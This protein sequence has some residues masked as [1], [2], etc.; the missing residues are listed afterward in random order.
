[1]ERGC[2]LMRLLSPRAACVRLE[3]TGA[4]VLAELAQPLSPRALARSQRVHALAP[5]S[6]SV[7]LG[8]YNVARHA[9]T[10][11]QLRAQL[12]ETDYQRTGYVK[13]K[14]VTEAPGPAASGAPPPRSGPGP[15]A[16]SLS[17]APPAE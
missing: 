5:V 12:P 10:E 17:A 16:S 7:V 3:D 4:F 1:M 14:L 6:G 11:C 13:R 15:G 2:T 8:P 9:F